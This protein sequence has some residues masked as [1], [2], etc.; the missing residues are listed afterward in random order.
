MRGCA[1]PGAGRPAR[2]LTWDGLRAI[3]AL[4][5]GML[6]DVL[7]H[8][9]SLLAPPLCGVCREPCAP[10]DSLCH[11]CRRAIG[12]SEPIEVPVAGA[13]RAVA[14][15][16]YDGTARRLVASLKFG[17]RLP[18]AHAAA[19][20]I[21]T[22]AGDLLIDAALVPVPPA[23]GRARRRGFDSATEI[24]RAISSSTGLELRPC[25]RRTSGPRQVGRTRTRRLEDPPRVFAVSGVPRRA[26]LVD[27]VVTTGATLAA[28]AAAL[29]VG[30]GETVHAVAFAH[31]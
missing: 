1:L 21:A 9:L 24:A 23:P 10:E 3:G 26:V 20:A 31:S 18:L 8:A 27:D 28:C 19:E 30:G 22:A 12:R 6:R 5:A 17:A 13:D 16:R 11:R 7:A 15:C 29:R 4:G 14:A 2:A 25:L